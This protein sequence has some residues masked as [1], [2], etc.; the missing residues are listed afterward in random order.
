MNGTVPGGKP[1]R[2]RLRADLVKAGV[3]GLC[4]TEQVAADLARQGMRPRQAWRHASETP[5]TCRQGRRAPAGEG[6]SGTL[7]GVAR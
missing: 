1:Y 3:T 4:L 2:D 5:L 6:L 7:G